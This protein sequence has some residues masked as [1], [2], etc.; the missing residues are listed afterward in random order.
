MWADKY[1][2]LPAEGKWPCW[3]LV[4]SVWKR[5]LG[6]VMPSFEGQREED[7]IDLGSAN[8]VSV[9][10]TQEAPFD[11]LLNKTNVI[12]F[13][14]FHIGVIVKK[15]LVLHVN[16]GDVSLIDHVSILRPFKLFRGP[17][18]QRDEG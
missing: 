7:A 8:F 14:K 9:I 13:P 4:R 17:W 1:V 2:G 15:G 12:G 11:A 16:E 18:K 5:E 10:P 3:A 6:F